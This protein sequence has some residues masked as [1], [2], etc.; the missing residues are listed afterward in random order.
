M[1]SKFMVVCT[2]DMHLRNKSTYGKE[3]KFHRKICNGSFSKTTPFLHI[4]LE[5]TAAIACSTSAHHIKFK[6]V[7]EV[8][9]KIDKF[10]KSAGKLFRGQ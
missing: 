6:L 4:I 2:N 10:V 3:D 5:T 7:I 1:K 8:L 9:K